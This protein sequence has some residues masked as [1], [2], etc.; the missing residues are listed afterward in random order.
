[1]T[2]PPPFNLYSGEMAKLRNDLTGQ[3]FGRLTVKARDYS[4]KTGQAKWLCLCDPRLGGC[5]TLTT[6]GSH[7]LRSGHTT[8]CGCWRREILAQHRTTHGLAPRQG[9]PRAYSSWYNMIARC[10]SESRPQY[11]DWG[12]RGITFDPR[13]KDFANFLADMGERPRGMSLERRDNSDPYCKANCVWATQHQQMMNTRATKLTPDVVTE[14]K[15]LRATGMQLK[16]IG[17]LMGLHPDTVTRALSGK[18]RQRSP[19]EKM[20]EAAA[21]NKAAGR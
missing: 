18:T 11:K 9:R 7:A 8:S 4:N 6:A 20:K 14:V 15:R 1:M 2:K 19:S 21:R 13:W 3:E 10:T 12:G 17:K 16:A 5:G